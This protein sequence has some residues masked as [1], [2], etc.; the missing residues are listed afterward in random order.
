MV[1][2]DGGFRVHGVVVAQNQAPLSNCTVA[3]KGPPSALMC[4]DTSLSPPEVDVPFTV[5]PAKIGYK[6]IFERAGFQPEE[7][8]FKYAAD[9]SPSKPLEL[10]VITL[11]PSPQ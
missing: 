4:C 2:C 9:A 7:R 5:G 10:G 1:A 3:L 8:D 11:R 6:L